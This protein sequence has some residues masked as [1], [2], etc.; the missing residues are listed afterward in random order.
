MKKFTI[1][2]LLLL[3]ALCLGSA[4]A[5]SQKGGNDDGHVS[6]SVEESNSAEDG[7]SYSVSFTNGDG[8]T[9]ETDFNGNVAQSGEKITFRVNV[10]AFYTGS[11]VVYVN[12]TPIAPLAD[13]SYA[14]TVEEDSTVRVE[15]IRKDVSNMVGSGTMEDAFVVSKPIDL[16]YIAQ[17]VNAGNYRYA[18]GAY[19]LAND[20]DCKG[21]ELEVIGDMRTDSATFSGCFSCYTDSETGEME[22]YTISNFTITTTDV[23]YVGLFGTVSADPSITSSGLFYGIRLDNFTINA[24]IDESYNESKSMSVGGLIGYGVGA[25]M[26]MCDATNGTINVVGD[27]SY[28]SFAGGLIGYQQ[29][30]YESSYG[31]G[32]PS[33]ISY[34]KVDVDVNVLS[35]SALYAGGITGYMATNYPVSAVA[36]I[37]NSYAIGN[38]SG[39]LR[40]GGIAGGI[41]QYT[42]ISN[43]YATGDA[44]AKSNNSI[45]DEL[46]TS[47]EYCYSHAGGLVGFAENDS[48]VHDS[49]TAGKA[50]AY[51]KSGAAY[52][53]ANDIVGGGYPAGNVSVDS[54]PYTVENCLSK[55][56]LNNQNFFTNTLGWQ[57]YNWQFNKGE[58][59]TIFYGNTESAIV[60]SVTINYVSV[61]ENGNV[62][63]V[64][65]E[66]ATSKTQNFFDTSIQ[67]TNVYT[68]FGDWLLN[69]LDTYYTADA[70][71]G[72]TAYLSYGYFFD[73]Q[74]TMP[75]PYSYLPAKNITLY[76]GFADPTAVLGTYYLTPDSNS[77]TIQITFDKDG[78]VTYSDGITGEQTAIYSYDGKTLL[79]EGARFARYFS[80]DGV[81][82]DPAY[83][84]YYNFAGEL[85]EDGVVL[86][87]GYYYTK[88]NPLTASKTAPSLRGAYYT[89]TKEYVFYGETALVESL[90]HGVYS[91]ELYTIESYE[92]GVI[93]LKNNTATLQVS[94]SDL[95]EYDEFK[96]SWTKSVNVNKTYTFDGKG[97][98]EYVHSSYARNGYTGDE[99]ILERTTGTYDAATGKF[100]HNGVEYTM[101]FNSDGMLEVVNAN[102]TQTFY[103]DNS[104]QGVWQNS[105]VVLTLNGIN[106]EN[107][108]TA[109]ITYA[110]GSYID[111]VYELDE[112]GGLMCL[113]WAHDDYWKDQLFGY[114][115]YDMPSH[116]LTTML[117][118]SA[119]ETGYTQV[120]LF[121]T[122]EY[123]GEW[124]CN[125]EELRNV[126]FNFNGLGLYG[127]LYA[128]VNGELTLTEN[129]KRTTVSYS[130]DSTLQGKFAYNG[131]MYQ[132]T[133]DEDTKAVVLT[134]AD[135]EAVTPPALERKDEFANTVFVDLEGN[136][137]VFD[138]RS[139]LSTGGVLKVNNDKQ[140]RYVKNGSNYLV[141]SGEQSVGTLQANDSYYG[142]TINGTQSRLYI[143]NE[144]MGTWAISGMF[145]SFT[146]QAT[147]LQGGIRANFKG[148]DVTM[149]YAATDI[150][151]FSYKEAGM[152]MTYYVF[153]MEE[154][155]SATR[156]AQTILVLSES[157]DLY[158]EYMICTKAD[159][160]F[161]T[162]TAGNGRS[163]R[164]DGVNSGYVES[165]KAELYDELLGITVAYNYNYTNNGVMLWTE[166]S[167]T[168][169][170]YK[171]DLQP[172]TTGDYTYKNG[173]KSFNL[174]KASF[175]YLVTAK[176]AANNQ[177]FFD[178]ASKTNFEDDMGTILDGVGQ[179]KV[180]GT[181]KYT[182]VITASDYVSA[183]LELTDV[184]TGEKST[185]ALNF[186]DS[187]NVIWEFVA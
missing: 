155:A 78:Y 22:R 35:G 31:M 170:Y 173:T 64:K 88:E 45:N 116:T 149:H 145:A 112:Q 49:Y 100:T 32:F 68:T 92:N 166:A 123:E 77:E 102:R 186:S 185:A 13:G 158:G 65:V 93:T 133:Y 17:Q 90:I 18:T 181:L 41:G 16:L 53:T 34:S 87:D 151:S 85:T 60:L 138:G 82:F 127:F 187:S 153:I 66:N 163:I 122:D 29:A 69:G 136:T 76:V 58:H 91:S 168:I 147:D 43:C 134:A 50:Y 167:E 6:S 48:V 115:L 152:P 11:P 24:S 113:Y 131:K 172:A 62:T 46:A 154:A 14:I 19:I 182:Y 174:V 81:L 20:I 15:G 142:L 23:N 38:V 28:F 125:A 89:E 162:W 159:A 94:F 156:P 37:Q 139:N 118:D 84:G 180:N 67:S 79:V 73:E 148:Y 176:D 39:A 143:Q 70:A 33:E 44:I 99:T 104:Y 56:D 75:V 83:Y 146:I 119:S 107:K 169:Y 2:T 63:P 7:S 72:K 25:N 30:F 57:S 160:M 97:N 164:F 21:E 9:F 36:S 74:C 103:R 110:D 161:G 3:S 177:Y 61:D 106:K 175:L 10:S 150:L 105:G 108:G 111:L 179:I 12:S 26:I 183:T 140:Y 101:S 117:Y 121:V 120:S 157:P 59:P 109:L 95:K 171:A 98:F 51:A 47:E 128:G 178:T 130:L 4:V 165:G 27:N 80:E 55:I 8:Y 71:S 144:F 184:A 132:M 5:C 129:G 86:Y 42:V 124:I 1:A 114:F 137:Y 126:E 135:E 52:A 141:Y 40:T 96:G 54:K